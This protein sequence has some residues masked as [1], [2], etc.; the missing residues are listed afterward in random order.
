MTLLCHSI[1]DLPCLNI[2]LKY[3]GQHEKTERL[4]VS[5]VFSKYFYRH[6]FLFSFLFL[7]ILFL[8]LSAAARFP[9]IGNELSIIAHL[10]PFT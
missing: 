1:V 10:L 8:P 4:Q 3:N 5:C 7:K 9:N 6:F 2:Y